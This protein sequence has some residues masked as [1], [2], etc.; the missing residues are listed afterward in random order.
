MRTVYL[1]ILSISGYR[2]SHKHWCG[3]PHSTE[4]LP[5]NQVYMSEFYKE[6]H[7]NLK[8]LNKA[9]YN[10]FSDLFSFYQKTVDYGYINLK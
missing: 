5:Q 3:Y 4:W 8:I 1:K 6:S 2:R 7:V 9:D 10:S